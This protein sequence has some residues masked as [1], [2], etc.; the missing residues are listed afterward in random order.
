VIVLQAVGLHYPCRMNI[1]QIYREEWGR[2]LAS[3]I[4]LVGSF[5]V[6]EE[7]V[8]EGFAAAVAH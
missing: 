5:D 8:Q 2:V 4:R 6:A 1:E 7:A 3:V